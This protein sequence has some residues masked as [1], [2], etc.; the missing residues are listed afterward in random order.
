MAPT[1]IHY[2][3]WLWGDNSINIQGLIIVLEFCLSPHCHLSINQ[4]SFQCQQQFLS[5]SPDKIPDRRTDRQTKWRLHVYASPFGEHKNPLTYWKLFLI[6]LKVEMTNEK[7][8]DKKLHTKCQWW[9]S[10][11]KWQ[12]FG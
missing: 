9:V 8:V 10:D 7:H 4:V 2:E 3:K 5:Y 11:L 1:G 12:H 6:L